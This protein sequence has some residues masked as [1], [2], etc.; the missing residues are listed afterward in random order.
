MARL[1]FDYEQAVKNYVEFFCIKQQ[2][3]FDFWVADLIGMVANF[4]DY[5]FNFDDIRFDIDQE[6]EPNQIIEYHN[7]VVEH[8][9]KLN[10]RS[11][12]MGAR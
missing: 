12:T 9:S 7:Y 4:G 10:Y 5:W 11:Y 6:I 8:E 1:K 2:L 3:E